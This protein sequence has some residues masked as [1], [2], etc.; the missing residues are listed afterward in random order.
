MFD[1]F[2]VDLE[3]FGRI[4]A[5]IFEHGFVH[6][7]SAGFLFVASEIFDFRKKKFERNFE[8]SEFKIGFRFEARGHNKIEDREKG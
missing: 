1:A 3:V 2:K 8:N 4:R 5:R 7:K 6:S